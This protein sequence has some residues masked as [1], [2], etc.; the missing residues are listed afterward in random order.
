MHHTDPL[1]NRHL[2]I[3]QSGTYLPK[4]IDI[5]KISIQNTNYVNYENKRFFYGALIVFIC[6]TDYTFLNGWKF[7]F[8]YK[9]YYSTCSA[10]NCVNVILCFFYS[11]I[12]NISIL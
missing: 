7:V 11:L 1:E 3:H 8:N 4:I 6:E 12:A 9:L 5:S 2:L 10:C